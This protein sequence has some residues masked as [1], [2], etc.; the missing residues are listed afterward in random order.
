MTGRTDVLSLCWVW[1]LVCAYFVAGLPWLGSEGGFHGD[2]SFYTDATLRMLANGDWW[3]PEFAD[4]S[5]RLNKPLLVYWL[6]GCSMQAFGASLFAARLPFLLAGAMLVACSARLAR[7][8]LT[9]GHA[10]VADV[11]SAAPANPTWL[12]ACLV[13]GNAS[14]LPLATRCTPDIL[15][16]LAMTIAWVGLADLLVAR[17]TAAA[18]APWLWAGIGLAAAAK[19]GLALLLLIYAVVA[20]LVLRR[21]AGTWRQLLLS[22]SLL[23]TLVLAGA[24]LAPLWLLEANDPANNFLAD[25]VTTRLAPSPWAA[26]LVAGDYLLSLLRHFLPWALAPGFVWLVAR[27]VARQ[28]WAK[29]RRAHWLVLG[30]AGL[31]FVVFSAANVHRGRYLAPMY[32]LLAVALAPWVAAALPFRSSQWLLR[33]VLAG[34]AVVVLLLGVFLLRVDSLATVASLVVAAATFHALRERGRPWVIACL[35]LFVGLNLII[36][37]SLRDTFRSSCWDA[38][39]AAERIDATL[40]FEPSTASI[41]RILSLGRHDPKVWKIL[42]EHIPPGAVVMV[43]GDAVQSFPEADFVREP[44]GRFVH[45]LRVRPLL[46]VALAAD[47][48]AEF[49]GMHEPVHLVRRR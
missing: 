10:N 2:E 5:V 6:M 1:L 9:P 24:A 14:L 42:P 44:C 49:E 41:V 43:Q 48:A 19:G 40:G 45:R 21:E 32:P 47:P 17:R 18:A 8:L 36:V 27:P 15:L 39:A 35:M 7:S 11:R 34:L 38:A 23:P 25:Q 30:F 29:H 20:I 31:M 33:V 16:V 46:K 4:G 13:A 22:P 28:V 3:R 12:A 26:L 37:P